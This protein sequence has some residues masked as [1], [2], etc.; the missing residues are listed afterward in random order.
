MQSDNRMLAR[1]SSSEPV[2]PLK[3]PIKF[4]LLSTVFTEFM[5]IAAISAPKIEYN[6]PQAL[7]IIRFTRYFLAITPKPNAGYSASTNGPTTYRI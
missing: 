3:A 5:L 7:K 1:P 6:S 2:T 4:P